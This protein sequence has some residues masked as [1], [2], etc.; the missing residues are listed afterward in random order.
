MKIYKKG[1]IMIEAKELNREAFL[2]ASKKILEEGY[3]AYEEITLIE[4]DT[5]NEYVGLRVEDFFLN[6]YENFKSFLS[7]L[8]IHKEEPK[9]K[10]ISLSSE[11]RRVTRIW[12]HVSKNRVGFVIISP[13]KNE[14]SHEENLKRLNEL[15]KKVNDNCYGY[16][17]LSGRWVNG[18]TEE[19]YSGM[20]LFIPN[21]WDKEKCSD[22]TEYNLYTLA[23]KWMKEYGQDVIIRQYPG[24]DIIQLVKSY[25]DI[26]NI[27]KTAH[28]KTPAEVYSQLKKGK[29]EMFVF[30]KIVGSKP[31][32][33]FRCYEDEK[34]EMAEEKEEKWDRIT[35]KYKFMYFSL[36]KGNKKDTFRFVYEDKKNDNIQR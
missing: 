23:K 22:N 27:G 35:Q 6:N 2:E 9:D 16:Y 32:P 33:M 14:Y 34:E 31:I 17:G 29:K 24:I 13:F 11:E 21:V 5:K 4:E 20:I 25:G 7:K 19:E 28:F 18:D 1:N 3:D 12:Q 10:D 30:E 36:K 15:E 26:E 8:S